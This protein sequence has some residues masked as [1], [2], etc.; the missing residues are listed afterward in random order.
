MTDR[1]MLAQRF[2]TERPRLR[3]IATKLLGSAADADDAVQETW[4][5]LEQADVDRIDHLQA[6]LT[7]VVSRV[8]LD[9]LRAPRRTRERSWQVE[10]WRDEPVA[11]TADPADLVIQGDRVSV[12]LLVVLHHCVAAVGRRADLVQ[13]QSR[14]AVARVDAAVSDV[15]QRTAASAVDVRLVAVHRS[16]GARVGADAH[17]VDG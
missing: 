7:T 1:R 8:S 4:L 6:W 3:A 10:P 14:R 17:A 5:R 16:V 15:A 12:A 11:T 13:A 2:E 9:Q